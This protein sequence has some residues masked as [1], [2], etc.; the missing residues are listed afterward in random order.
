MP[1][2]IS[3]L[4]YIYADDTKMANVVNEK[5]RLEGT[6]ARFEKTTGMVR[7]MVTKI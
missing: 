5:K 6:S 2:T 7:E 1:D 3:S 4:I